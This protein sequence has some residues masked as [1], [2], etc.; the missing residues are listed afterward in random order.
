MP[1]EVQHYTLCDGWVN[2]WRDISEGGEET[3]SIYKTYIEALDAL[4]DFFTQEHE[5]FAEGNMESMY[6][7]D[8]FRI[9]EV[10]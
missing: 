5:A 10:L 4:T 7:I 8:E 3:P 1:F 2:T 6:D 9:M